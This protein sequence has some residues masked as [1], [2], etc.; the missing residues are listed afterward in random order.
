MAKQAK[1]EAVEEQLTSET[2]VMIEPTTAPNSS[3]PH[4][5]NRP[6]VAIAIVSGVVLFVVGLG[7]GYLLGKSIGTTTRRGSSTERPYN[8]PGGMQRDRSP[9]STT[10]DDNSTT[11]EDEATPETQTN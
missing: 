9:D 3:Q 11:T 10:P 5:V 4:K 2:S 6:L 8:L 1:Q 7:F